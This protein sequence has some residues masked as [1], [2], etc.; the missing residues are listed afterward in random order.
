[1]ANE[2]ENDDNNVQVKDDKKRKKIAVVVGIICVLLCVVGVVYI[3]HKQMQKPPVQLDVSSAVATVD[4]DKL[5]QNHSDYAKLEKLQAEKIL[6]LI[7]LKSYT[8]NTEQLQPPQVNPADQVFEQ[9]VNEQD[10]LQ[11]I[12]VKQQLKEETIAK[13]NEIRKRLSSDKNK[14]I[15]SVTD[16]YTNAILNCTV[17][18][19]N[20]KNLKLTEEEQN[21]I[22][23]I[24]EQLKAE[25]GEMAAS[26]EQQYN[27]KVAD[28][29]MQWR[30]QREA[31]LG[32]NVQ[33][34]H[35]K[36]VQN[37]LERQQAEQQR[38]AQYLQDRLQML[39]ARKKD[40]ER[41]IILLHTKENEINLLKKSMLKDIASKAMKV[42]IQKHLKLVIA[43]VPANL[44]FFGNIKIDNFDNTVLNG[45]VVGVDAIDITDDVISEL[46]N[47][48]KQQ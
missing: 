39:Q 29:L 31:E 47:T 40:S 5:I 46:T 32:V 15:A 6:I 9:V 11:D 24:L 27:L 45:M 1:M 19:D 48:Q 34:V 7:K 36:D 17:K 28:E 14:A 30:K 2:Q 23:D 44:D 22:L 42:A 25:R 26:I 21:K 35:Q 16:K 33:N 18:L 12:K 43:D 4:I 13:E 20:A 3:W 10:N 41:L 38:D 8:L 37:S